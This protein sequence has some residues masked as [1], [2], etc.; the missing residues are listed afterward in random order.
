AHRLLESRTVRGKLLLSVGPVPEV[1]R[2]A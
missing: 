2:G 1:H